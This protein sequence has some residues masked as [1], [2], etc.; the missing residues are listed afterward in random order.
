MF[1][2]DYHTHTSFSFDGAP[3]STPD[4]LCRR[5]LEL[6]LSDLAITDHCDVNGEA[7]GIYAPYPTDEAFA[8]MQA[9]KEKYSGRMNLLCGIELG[10]ATQ[11]PDRAAAVLAAHPYD[12][13]IGSLHNLRNVPDFCMLKYDM[14]TDTHLH[15]LFDRALDET[16][17]MCAFEGIHTLGHFTYMHRYVTAA[18]MT[19]SFAPHMEKIEHLYRTLICRG[20]ALELNV[21]SLRRGLGIAMPTL[22]L[23]K[24]YADCGGKLVT[25][26]SDAHTPADLAKPIRKGYALLGAAGFDSVAVMRDGALTLQKI[27]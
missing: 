23:L 3:D 27:N 8:A 7:E 2:C 15:R 9:A 20:I 6:G 10:N 19:F 25:V 17:E 12:F 14:M 13:V 26:G 5:A 4:A 1:L 16:I 21:S 22:E 18:G 24:F 11:Y